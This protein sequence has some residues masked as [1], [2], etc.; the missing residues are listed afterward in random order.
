[1]DRR[2]Q[3]TRKAIFDAFKELLEKHPY[4]SITIQN[5]IDRA[6]IGRTTFYAHFATKD[7][8]TGALC[9]ELFD[10]VL[11]TA[12][13]SANQH[14]PLLEANGK[15]NSVFLHI[16]LHLEQNENGILT[17]LSKDDSGIANRHF[18]ERLESLARKEL[19]EKPH[20]E[21]DVDEDFLVSHISGSFVNMV[22]WWL[23]DWKKQTPARLAAYFD[24]VMS[25]ILGGN[26]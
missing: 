2:Q 4:Q 22:Q 19:H 8:L 9:A 10:H 13:D 6:N 23:S 14:C 21:L 7:E 11:G 3:K 24:T 20:P 5:I 17:L 1:M 16:L 15:E 18:R 26:T 12:V 25:P